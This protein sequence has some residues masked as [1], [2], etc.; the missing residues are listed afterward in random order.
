MLHYSSFELFSSY[1]ELIV[2]F[3][4]L[5]FG[6]DPAILVVVADCGLFTAT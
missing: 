3:L 1:M 6:D 2:G 5:F 4:G